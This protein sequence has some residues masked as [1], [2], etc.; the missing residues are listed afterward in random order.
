MKKYVYVKLIKTHLKFIE[1]KMYSTRLEYSSCNRNYV[2][3]K[4]LKCDE[5]T[6]IR[7][8]SRLQMLKKE[9]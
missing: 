4:G 6:L 5:K 1:E 9:R 7:T 3:Q 8:L 2:I